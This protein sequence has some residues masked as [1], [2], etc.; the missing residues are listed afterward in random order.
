[1]TLQKIY[2]DMD[3]VLAN[4]NHGLMDLCGIAP[5]DQENQSDEYSSRMWGAVRNIPHFYDKLDPIP[6]TLDLFQELYEKYGGK[7]EILTAI[8]KKD[9]GIVT[10]GEDKISWA[11]RLLGPDVM[12]NIVYKEQK[13]EFCTGPDCILVDDLARNIRE[14]TECGGTGILFRN[15]EEAREKLHEWEVL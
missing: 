13:K 15:A 6:G 5:Q 11:H 3:G 4:F 9:K 7:C 12:V 1:M 10:A 2:F 8:P 14:W